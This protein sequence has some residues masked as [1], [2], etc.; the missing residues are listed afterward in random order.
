MNEEIEVTTEGVDDIPLLLAQMNRMGLREL[1]DQHFRVHGNW[2]GLTLGQVVTTW[3]AHILSRHDHRLNQVQGWATERQLL[4][5]R[6][7]DPAVRP[8]DFS[9]DRLASALTY[10]GDDPPWQEFEAAANQRLVRV[11]DLQVSMMRL[12]STSSSGYWSV[13]P[14]G[15]FQF[16]PSKDHRPDLPQVKVMIGAL[17]PLGL[18][19]VTQV[20]GG[21]RADDRLYVPVIRQIRQSLK[22]IGL[23]YVGDVKMMALLTRAVIQQGQDYYL[24]PLAP[25]QL[26]SDGLPHYLTPVWEGQQVLTPVYR[27]DGDGTS[28]LLAEG[29]ETTLTRSKQVGDKTVVWEERQLILRSVA[30]SEAQQAALETRLTKA[31]T[32]LAALNVYKQ[33]KKRPIEIDEV[34]PKVDALLRKHQVA[35]L[36]D[37]TYALGEITTPKGRVL[38]MVQLTVTRNETAIHDAC[39]VMGWRVYATNHTAD[40][41]SLQQAVFAYREQYRV[42]RNFGRLKGTPLSL[43]PTY[44]ADDQR[45]TGLIRLLSLGLKV[46][47]LMESEVREALADQETALAGLYQGNP[48]RAT[49]RPTAERLLEAFENITLTRVTMGDQVH[50]HVSPLSEVQARILSLLNFPVTIYTAIPYGQTGVVEGCEMAQQA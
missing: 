28:V 30:Q 32:A 25:R 3:L 13:T 24:G 31:M 2:Q 42:E 40:Q 9:D 16:G 43:R 11:Y 17:D 41:L 35:G 18:P 26:P 10:L 37:V 27:I 50:Y 4:L 49:A 29:Y 48:K 46:L 20:V 23:T 14:E 19:L 1:I 22:R 34:R 8:L 36:L 12:D 5:Q 39:A 33:G 6:C 47:T 38:P 45:V 7:V 44:L 15:L 21:R